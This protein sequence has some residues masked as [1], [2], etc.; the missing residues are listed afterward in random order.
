MA[1]VLLSMS[2]AGNRTIAEWVVEFLVD[3]GV[4]RVYGHRGSHVQPIWD[5][6]AK[7]DVQIVHARRESAAVHMAHCH[8]VLTGRP[9]VVLVNAESGVTDCVTAIVNARVQRVPIF[10]IGACAPVPKHDTAPPQ[11]IDCV[12]IMEPATR[13]A[14]TF[15]AGDSLLGE[16]DKFWSL[17]VG[18]GTAP[19]PAYAEFPANVLRRRI[20]AELAL[21]GYVNQRPPLRIVPDTAEISRA[22]ALIAAAHRPVVVTGRGALTAS[23]ELLNF[24]QSA[25]AV[26]LQTQ[27]TVGL[28]SEAHPS[29]ATAAR[30]LVEREAD[31]VIVVGCRVDYHIGGDATATF[32]NARL[33]SIADNAEELTGKRRCDV[34]LFAS[35]ALALGALA[36]ALPE[37]RLLDVGWT[38]AVH[39]EHVHCSEKHLKALA[40]APKGRDGHMHPYQIFAALNDVLDADAIKIADGG[41]LLGA[42]RLGFESARCYVDPGAIGCVGVATPYAIAAALLEPERQVVA[43][44]DDQA[45]GVSAPEIGTAKDCGARAL[46]V[47]ASHAAQSV[48]AVE[49]QQNRGEGGRIDG[50]SLRSRTLGWSRAFRV[51]VERVTDTERLRPAFK[52]A[53]SRLPSLVEV[54]VT[55][56][57]VP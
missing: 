6:L 16:L 17:A 54:I 13:A 11:G 10:L 23:A 3:R 22:A 24:L 31:L 21:H 41:E 4:D 53:L 7:R 42:A 25:G 37:C 51:H 56:H 1:M 48:E 14:G 44:S 50:A 27:E 15:H 20:P 45:F 19:G 12:A 28:V 5:E 39:H 55:S 18:E 43:I 40:L 36:R 49:R 34:E 30:S 47:V 35:P 32:R 29:N 38:A 2:A 52:E 9:G 46:F 57:A 26:Y 33:I 8:G